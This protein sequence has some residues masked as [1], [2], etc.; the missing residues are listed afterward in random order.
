MPRVHIANE[1]P[2]S[3]SVPRAFAPALVG[4]VELPSRRRAAL[5]GVTLPPV[6]NE[7]AAKEALARLTEDEWAQVTVASPH[8]ALEL[9]GGR[10]AIRGTERRLGLAASSVVS[11]S[12]GPRFSAGRDGSISHTRG[13]AVALLVEQHDPS[14][15][16]GI[17]VERID[18]PKRRL[19]HKILTASELTELER[20]APHEQERRLTLAFAAKEAAYKAIHRFVQRYVAFHEVELSWDGTAIGSMRAELTCG[21]SL[22]LRAAAWS[23]SLGAAEVG[24]SVVEA[25]RR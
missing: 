3:G 22:D 17:D 7:P 4:D 9:A 5:C 2:S 12:G 11:T 16:L 14:R 25:T 23:A 1:A 24:L 15:G 10:V 21:A 20:L 6:L 18:R 8:R 13:L 19:A